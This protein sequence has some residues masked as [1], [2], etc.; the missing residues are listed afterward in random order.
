[1]TAQ[2]PAV[3]GMDYTDPPYP[4]IKHLHVRLSAPSYATLVTQ[5]LIER[6]S[7]AEVAR[8]WMRRGARAEGHNFDAF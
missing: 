2:T 1:M 4:L 5:S 7:E 3:D 8:R 6:R